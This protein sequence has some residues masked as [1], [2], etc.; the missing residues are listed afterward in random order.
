V[1]EPRAVWV[2]AVAED[3]PTAGV[4][5][6]DGV[7]GG[8]VRTVW[9]A[10]LTAI[11]GEV[12]LEEFG[13]AALRRNLEDLA[14]LEATARAHHRVIEAVAKQGP[15]VPMRL[16]TVY[17][18]DASAAAAL[19][20]RGDD[21]RAAL[22]WTRARKEWGV[23]AYASRSEEPPSGPAP[24][25]GGPAQPRAGAGAAYLRRRRHEISGHENARRE[26][27]A[28][29][30]LIHDRLS[31]LAAGT[32]LHP[33]QAPQL[34]GRNAQMILNAS[35]LLDETRDDDFAA[36]VAALDRQHPA[37]RLE[38][39]GPWPPYSFAGTAAGLAPGQG[40]S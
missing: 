10:G 6:L 31:R 11:A 5:H 7:G 29:V 13:E 30:E 38:L 27:I 21:L 23:K 36:E 28:S 16:A 20:E 19:A 32:R 8:P 34:A 14:W 25:P 40:R 26:A 35:Y 37:V 15:L 24:A 17:S 33:P 9:A 18:D 1:T 2:Y 39:T 4:A 12:P 3:V 22:G